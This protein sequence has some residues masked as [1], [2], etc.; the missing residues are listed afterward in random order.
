LPFYGPHQSGIA[1]PAQDRLH[2]A[3]FDVVTDSASE[4]RDLLRT[5]TAAAA[6][7]AAGQPA[8]PG[9]DDPDA[10]PDDTG[11]AVGLHPARLTITFGFGPSLF[12][13]RRFRLAPRPPAPP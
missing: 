5:W 8:G 7:M 6:L 10:P 9:N 11:E 12:L 3:A 4:L 13:G 2:F 1:T